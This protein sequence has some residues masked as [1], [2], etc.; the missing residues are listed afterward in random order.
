[1]G[2][3]YGGCVVVMVVVEWVLLWGLCSGD[4]G[5]GF[6]YGG[7]VVGMVVEVLA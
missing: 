1:M 3:C 5:V 6:C 4:G 2:F 7:C